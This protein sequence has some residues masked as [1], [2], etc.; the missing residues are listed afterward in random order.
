VEDDI[1]HTGKIKWFNPEKGYGFI[2]PDAGG[3]DIFLH[4]SAVEESGLEIL[5]PGQAVR[6]NIETNPDNGS[7]KS[8][9][10]LEAMS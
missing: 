6:F 1:M 10:D 3:E 5:D 8:A 2:R 9:V 7:K 4:I